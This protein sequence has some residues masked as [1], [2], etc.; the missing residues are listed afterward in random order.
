MAR[1]NAAYYATHDPYA[2]FTTAPEISQVFGEI[3]GSGPP[4]PGQ[5]SAGRTRCCWPRPG[6]GR[7]TLM[8]DA[9]R[10]IARAAP[11]FRR[12]AAAAPDRDLARAAREPRRAACRT[13]LARQLETLP[14][15]RCCCSPTSSSTPC[16]SASSC[17]AAMAGRSGSS[18]KGGSSSALPADIRR[19]SARR[20]RAREGRG[21]LRRLGELA[22]CAIAA[23]ARPPALPRP[24]R[25]GAVPRLRPR[26][27]HRAARACRRCAAAARRSARRAG[28]GRPH[29]PCR[30][31][32]PRRRRR[33]AG[34][35]VQARC[36]RAN[37]SPPSACSS[38][39]TGSRA[40]SARRARWR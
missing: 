20:R 16:R 40:A 9:L 14:P 25:R 24:R 7:G 33:A 11:G 29:R 21:R 19:P 10:A 2:D 12:R 3:L 38:A 34:A 17:A 5:A 8:A 4:W 13:R 1:A 26:A 37:S 27:Q 31:R 15:G 32:R 23:A 39:P 30:F 35:A 36:R 18:P 22:G 6:P 28:L